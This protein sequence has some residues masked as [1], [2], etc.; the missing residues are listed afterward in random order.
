VAAFSRNR[1]NEFMLRPIWKNVLLLACAATLAG[2]TSTPTP[3]SANGGMFRQQNEGYSLLYKLMSDDSD[4]SKIVIFT[5]ADDSVVSLIKEIAGACQ[6]AKK[7]M[8]EFP[9]SD[10][11][12][13]YDVP[14]LPYIEAKGRDQQ[15]SDDGHMLLTS[16]GKEFEVQL[17]VSQAQATDYAMQ[18]SKALIENEK[19]PT[20]QAFLTNVSKQFADFHARLMGLLTIKS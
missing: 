4:V 11:R 8:D 16:S 2:C 7:Q 20:R 14:D 13:E 10:N 3:P 19:D 6:A 17:I 15:A 12:I 18:L 9:K 5:R 1:Y